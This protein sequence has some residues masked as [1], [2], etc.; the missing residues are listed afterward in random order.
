MRTHTSAL[1]YVDWPYVVYIFVSA[2]QRTFVSYSL[3]GSLGTY[4]PFVSV[5]SEVV[6]GL[7]PSMSTSKIGY[8]ILARCNVF[9]LYCR[10]GPK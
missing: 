8:S 2:V 6:L 10:V 1:S 9:G 3:V 5:I 4:R 7:D